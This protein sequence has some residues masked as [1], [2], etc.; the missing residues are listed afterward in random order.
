MTQS[1]QQADVSHKAAALS[2]RLPAHLSRVLFWE[3]AI[4]VGVAISVWGTF[5]LRQDSIVGFGSRVDFLG[6]YV[7]ARAVATGHGSQI[8]DL[9]LQRTLSDAAILPYSRGTLMPYVYPAYVAVLFRPLGAIAFRTALQIW[10]LINLATILWAASRLASVFARGF[11]ERLAILAVF[12]AW[13][14]F[15][16][17]LVQGQLGI[18]PALGI[19]EALIALRSGHEWR[20]GWWLSLGLIKPQLILFPLL[21]FVIWRCWRT[22]LAFSIALAGILGISRATVGFWIPS[23]T[24]FL[25]DYNRRGEELSLNPI[26]MQNWRA[27]ACWLL[28][29]E[30]SSAVR[31]VVLVLGVLSFLVVFVMCYRRSRES[32]RG[33]ASSPSA[34]ACYAS[35]VLL[36]LLSSPHLYMHDWVVALPVGFVLW[37]FARESYSETSSGNYRA[38][39]LL[40]LLGVAPAIFFGAQFVWSGPTAPVYV[41]VVV[42]A[43]VCTLEPLKNRARALV[44]S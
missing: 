15:Q 4:L 36:G 17:T 25:L 27:L 34:E 9:E 16:L 29:T 39:V 2:P 32:D 20:A 30:D 28:R 7:G 13:V 42:A 18:L 26:A 21:V 14:P 11:G 12:L 35:A 37:F 40:W 23:Y 38:A 8:Y 19:I 44:A 3:L 31:A 41:A 6:I 1:T 10:V 43:A 33:F 24:R 22:I 5:F